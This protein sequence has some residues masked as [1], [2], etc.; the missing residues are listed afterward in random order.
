MIHKIVFFP[1]PT[2]IVE[3]LQPKVNC[4]CNIDEKYKTCD[5]IDNMLS[6]ILTCKEFHLYFQKYK[7]KNERIP[8]NIVSNC[9]MSPYFNINYICCFHHLKNTNYKE[10]T[11]TLK[12]IDNNREKVSNIN[13]SYLIDYNLPFEFV[14]KIK[15]KNASVAF[16]GEDCS[17]TE[18]TKVFIKKYMNNVEIGNSCCTGLGFY[19]TINKHL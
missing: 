15:D 6:L 1:I 11:K 2:L 13:I 9:D 8:F 16:H 12:L 3:F 19:M 18:E 4:I 14:N 17:D 10:L 5:I 7:L